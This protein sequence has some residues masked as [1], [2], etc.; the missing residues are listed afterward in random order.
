MLSHV[1]SVKTRRLLARVLWFFA[2]CDISM[3]LLLYFYRERSRLRKTCSNYYRF[4]LMD[5]CLPIPCLQPFASSP[6]PRFRRQPIGLVLVPQTV[7]RGIETYFP[8]Y[9]AGGQRQ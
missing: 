4:N 1:V 2:C 5:H 9:V 6:R 3:A 7:S 8:E